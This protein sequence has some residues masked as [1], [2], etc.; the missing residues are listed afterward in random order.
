M[1]LRP[2]C[3]FE[4]NIYHLVI[5]NKE[6]NTTELLFRKLLSMPCHFFLKAVVIECDL[7]PLFCDI[8]DVL[9]SDS[10]DRIWNILTVHPNYRKRFAK[11][12]EI[13]NI[14]TTQPS[15][16]YQRMFFI[17][18]NRTFWHDEI[19]HFVVQYPIQLAFCIMCFCKTYHCYLFLDYVLGMRRH[20]YMKI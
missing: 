8:K 1:K 17:F 18:Q 13:S 5:Y 4:N 9:S 3:L 6:E 10:S 19:I 15:P 11:S 16:E 2:I 20:R 12:K 7:K 14:H